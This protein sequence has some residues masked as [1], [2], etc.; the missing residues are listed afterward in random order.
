MRRALLGGVGRLRFVGGVSGMSGSGKEVWR[1]WSEMVNGV[2]LTSTRASDEAA[3]ESR[4]EY[5]ANSK[6]ILNSIKTNIEAIQTAR[7]KRL[8]VQLLGSRLIQSKNHL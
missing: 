5:R 7:R 4:Y 8:R 2:L 6:E 1:F 3:C